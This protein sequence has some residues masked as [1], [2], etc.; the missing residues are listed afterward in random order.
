MSA[1]PKPAPREKKT[2]KRIAR[3]G[4]PHSVNRKRRTKEWL[5]TYGSDERVKWVK[6]LTCLVYSPGFCEGPIENAHTE[7]GGCGRRADADTIVPLCKFHHA[8]LH[9]CGRGVWEESREISLAACA[10]ETERRWQS[11]VSPVLSETERA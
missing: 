11:H 4:I 7:S 6:S 5:R 2:P 10:L 9:W 3:T 1:V 8:Q